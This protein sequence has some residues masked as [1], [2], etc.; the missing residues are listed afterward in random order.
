MKKR[1][2]GVGVGREVMVRKVTL[3]ILDIILRTMGSQWKTSGWK[4]T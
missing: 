4:V 3:K 1:A 2:A